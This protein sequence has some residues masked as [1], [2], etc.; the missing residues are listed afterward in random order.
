MLNKR[1]GRDHYNAFSAALRD[2]EKLLGGSGARSAIRAFIW[3]FAILHDDD[4]R[5]GR[6]NPDSQWSKSMDTMMRDYQALN[7]RGDKVALPLKAKGKGKVSECA[8]LWRVVD[9]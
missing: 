1:S 7:L 4:V 2:T 3:I 6:V 8:C 9:F 5:H